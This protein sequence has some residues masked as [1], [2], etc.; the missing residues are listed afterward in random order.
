MPRDPG[1][2]SLF[3]TVFK[4]SQNG[5]VLLDEKRRCVEVNG[6]IL[7]TLGY[8]RDALVGKPVWEIVKGGPALTVDEWRGVLARKEFAGEADVIRADGAA[9]TVQYAAHPEVVTGRR[10]VLFVAVSVARHGRAHRRSGA[11]SDDPAALSDRER[12]IVHLVA[13]GRSGP[14]IADE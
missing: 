6:A 10:L 3:W 7:Q 4:L 12:Q 1:W 14:E 9:V 2:A 5:M 13:L 11:A 8:R